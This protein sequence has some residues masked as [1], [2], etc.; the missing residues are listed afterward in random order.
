M[1]P[2][3]VAPEA[4]RSFT[5]AAALERWYRQHHA[6][7]TELWLRLYKTGSGVASVSAREALDVAL[8]WGW[9]DAV[10]KSCDAESFLQR[11]TPRRKGSIWSQVNIANIERL[12]AAGRMQ[13]AG[14]A[15]VALAQADGRWARA[16]GS[17]KGDA[18]PA[19][20]TAAIAA[21]PRALALF[22]KLSAQN[23]FALA[24]RT[25]AMKTEAG[26]AR[27]IAALVAMLAR[28]ETPYPNG[29]A[30]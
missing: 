4:M 16:Y 15:E 29:K 6:S 2:V 7:A 30:K 21:E 17:F 27:K 26:R 5:A 12:R 10:R 28:G 9:I 20:L 3:V 18:F 14:E 1:A 22:E 25:H 8:C 19:D 23:R 24:F 13:P 11:Y